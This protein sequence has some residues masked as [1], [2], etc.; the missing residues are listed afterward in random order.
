MDRYADT[1]AGAWP[2]DPVV[3]PGGHVPLAFDFPLEIETPDYQR[4][5]LGESPGWSPYTQR[6]YWSPFPWGPGKAPAGFKVRPITPEQFAAEFRARFPDQSPERV[7]YRDAQR[8]VDVDGSLLSPTVFR[9]WELAR[10]PFLQFAIG[11]IERIATQ[12]EVTALDVTTGD[13]IF[14][15][16]GLNGEDPCLDQLVHPDP[17][18]ANPLRFGWQLVATGAATLGAGDGQ[19]TYPPLVVAGADIVRGAIVETWADMRNGYATFGVI[20]EKQYLANSH[21][22]MRLF[23]RFS[24]DPNVW[25]IRVGGRLSGFSQAAGPTGAALQSANQRRT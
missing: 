6:M 13:P 17:A 12:L 3:G 16:S 15:Y 25:Q 11:I 4:V 14:T 18:V 10:I 20:G 2:D 7:E 19:P 21:Q 22:L 5:G 1:I 8:C 23:A 9:A 24:G